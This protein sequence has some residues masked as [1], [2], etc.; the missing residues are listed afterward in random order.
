[1]KASGR[2]RLT[3]FSTYPS[4]YVAFESIRVTN[5]CG[6]VGSTITIMKTMGFDVTELS[7]AA[8]YWEEDFCC[9]KSYAYFITTEPWWTYTAMDLRNEYV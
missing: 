6:P 1:M 7:T 4:I 2:P 5:L 3:L 8:S 9:F